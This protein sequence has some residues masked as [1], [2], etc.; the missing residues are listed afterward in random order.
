MNSRLYV[1]RVMHQ[2]TRPVR[3]AF[4]YG[5]YYLFA[6]LD[7]LE[8]LDASLRLF[9]H[10]RGR[11]VSLW[12]VDHG[13]R[14]GSALRPWIDGLLREVG[15]DLAGGKVYLLTFPRVLGFTFW[16]VSFWYC[17]SADGTPV[18]VLAEVQNTF[19]DHHNYLLHNHGKPFDW[20]VRPGA[21]KVFYVSPFIQIEN[22]R[23][24]FHFTEPGDTLAASIYDYVEGPLLLT[25]AISVEARELTDR[26]LLGRVLRLGPMSARA[27]V[28]IHYQAVRLWRKRVPFFAHVP[29]PDQE[30]S[31]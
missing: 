22:A 13:P 4:R 26:A 8:Q 30:T 11:L 12:D 20:N 17:Y 31:L 15:I 23:Y 1:G 19:R 14:D 24:E 5:I 3:N 25:A 2:R 6:D 29:P 28:L 9:G 21:T 27:M 7:E 16:P 10:N 18:A